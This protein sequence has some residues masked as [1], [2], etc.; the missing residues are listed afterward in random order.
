M[1]LTI[2][3]LRSLL[4]WFHAIVCVVL[5]EFECSAHLH[6]VSHNHSIGFRQSLQQ[7]DPVSLRHH[8]A[9]LQQAGGKIRELNIRR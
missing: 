6:K 1:H 4:F 3:N 9:V 8:I 2:T 5:S 7:T